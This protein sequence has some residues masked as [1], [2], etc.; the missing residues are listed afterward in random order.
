MEET[1]KEKNILTVNDLCVN[2]FTDGL[3]L[4]VIAHVSFDVKEGETLGVVGESGCGKSMLASAIIGLIARPGKITGGQILFEGNDLT[5]F[6]QNDL[7]SIRGRKI[8][9]IFQDPMTSLNPIMTCGKQITECIH[10]HNKVSK[11][12]ADEKALEMIRS[13]GIHNPEKIFRQVPFQLSG[14]MRQRIMIAMALV[15]KP[16]LLI[17]D[18]PTTALDVTVQAQILKLIKH[19]Q[20]ET[21]TAVIFISHDMGVISEMSDKIAVMYAGHLIEYGTANEILN[22]PQHPYTK[23]LQA[24]IPKIEE[25]TEKLECIPGNVPMLDKI[26]SGCVFA[27]RCAFATEKCRESRPECFITDRNTGH[28]TACFYPTE[29]EISK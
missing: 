2:L 29:K 18:E 13:V 5:K 27:P 7:R 11:K 26:P 22:N 6:S 16:K 23:G 10:A 3:S 25:E 1:I 14:G 20:K 4:P 9:M 19:L 8:S 15:C 24:A 21:G 28:K 12:A 17:C